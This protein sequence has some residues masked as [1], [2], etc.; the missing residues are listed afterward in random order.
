MVVICWL[1]LAYGASLL[2]MGGM[3]FYMVWSGQVQVDEPMY[4]D[5]LAPALSDSAIMMGLGLV[6]ITVASA[7][8]SYKRRS[9]RR[10][11]HK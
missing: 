3:S 2:G 5:T 9:A 8:S 4:L 6:L 10:G 11:A 1:M 7:I